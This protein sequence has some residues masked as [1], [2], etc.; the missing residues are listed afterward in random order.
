MKRIVSWIVGPLGIA[1]ALAFMAP[2]GART[3]ARGVHSGQSGPKGSAEGR[4]LYMQNCAR[5]HG[6][7]A[8]GKNGPRLVTTALSREEIE[9]TV[10]EGRPPK[11]PGFG[12]QLSSA[13]VKAVASYVRS[14]RRRS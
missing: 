4:Q 8:M 5:C 9:Q 14:L 10:T 6:A 11:M 12:K 13:K 1:I 7:N 2:V 3:A